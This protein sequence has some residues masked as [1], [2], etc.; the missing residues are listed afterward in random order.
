MDEILILTSRVCS[1]V[2]CSAGRSHFLI[3]SLC[4]PANPLWTSRGKPV[5]HPISFLS[6]RFLLFWFL[7]H[8]PVSLLIHN[9]QDRSQIQED[10][11]RDTRYA[12]CCPS[13]SIPLIH[14]GIW[15]NC[16]PR[17]MRFVFPHRIWI[18]GAHFLR[19]HSQDYWS[20]FDKSRRK[21]LNLSYHSHLVNS[22]LAASSV[23]GHRNVPTVPRALSLIFN[24][25]RAHADPLS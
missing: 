7:C 13:W 23:S 10:E 24:D 20:S 15:L 8:N 21:Y 17:N 2:F 4:I 9:I 3:L 6:T 14:I 16:L 1:W 18:S 19:S 22:V 25:D 12:A 5:L 11:N